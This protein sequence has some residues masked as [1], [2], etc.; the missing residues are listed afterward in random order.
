MGGVP[1]PE[2]K[3]PEDRRCTAKS[4]QTGERCKRIVRLGYTV[5]YYHG[6]RAPGA[7]EKARLRLLNLVDPAIA[8]VAQIMATSSDEKTRLRAAE[9]VLDRG[10]FPRGVAVSTDDAKALLAERLIAYRD[11]AGLPEPD[12]NDNTEE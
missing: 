2:D 1:H 10:G 7:A 8:T 11:K 6:A 5:C 4:K 12:D 3:L 9:N